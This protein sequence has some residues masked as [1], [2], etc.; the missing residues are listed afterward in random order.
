MRAIDSDSLRPRYSSQVEDV[1]ES[2]HNHEQTNEVVKPFLAPPK[3]RGRPD[4]FALC[5][6]LEQAEQEAIGQSMAHAKSEINST[7][8]ERDATNLERREYMRKSLEEAHKIKNWGDAMRVFG[9]IGACLGVI[10]GI[11]LIATGAGAVAGSLLIAGGVVMLGNQ[12]MEEVGGWHKLVDLVPGENIED[13]KALVSWIQIGMTFVSLVLGA[14]SALFG[15][16]KMIGEALGKA[17]GLIG[18]IAGTGLGITQ[19]GNAVHQFYYFESTAKTK[20]FDKLLAALGHQRETNMERAQEALSRSEQ[21][22][23][24]SSGILRAQR[25]MNRAL[26][27]SIR[28]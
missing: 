28:R 13:R 20:Q 9:W 21:S 19:I 17:M 14:L 8:E 12:I 11:G 1:E 7:F 6:L 5:L 2:Q 24:I 23:E 22:S 3:L 26:Q 15:G 10:A 27:A 16:Y 25:D 4:M 18:A